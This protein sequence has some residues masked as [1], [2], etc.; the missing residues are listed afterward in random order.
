MRNK[1]QSFDFAQDKKIKV[2]KQTFLEKIIEKKRANLFQKTRNTQKVRKSDSPSSLS[3]LK[4]FDIKNEKKV[5]LIAEIKFASPTNPD[6]GQKSELFER[7]KQYE[8][9]GAD[10]ISIITEKHFF[11]GD[12]S[13]VSQI[14]KQV[15]IP[16]LQKDFVIDTQQIYEAKE[17][18]S[19]ALLLIARLVDTKT[20]IKFVKH[21][22]AEGIEPV[23]EINNE[24]DLKKAVA[25]DTNII[26]VNAR[27]LETFIINIPDA[28][29]LI[30]KI[31][32]RFIKLGFS[33]I[34]SS[35]EVLQYTKAGAK[36][37]LVGTSLMKTNDIN[38]F[39]DGLKI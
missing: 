7:A 37:V 13:L 10:A 4:V 36:G 25:T 2:K 34:H 14:K 24:E 35:S 11:N 3:F 21:C 29:L 39:L 18:G 28:C 31:P 26:A 32:N 20:L 38:S 12:V 8:L 23:V 9:S 33:G 17:I 16:V 15:T 19:D 22:F 5:G 30:K 27:D 1:T 6:L